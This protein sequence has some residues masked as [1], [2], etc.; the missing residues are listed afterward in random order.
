MLLDAL[1]GGLTQAQRLLRVHTPL[2]D[3]VLLAEDVEAWEGVGPADGPALGDARAFDGGSAMAVDI[4]AAWAFE[5]SLG[6]ARAGMRLVVHA[7]A[8]DAHIELKH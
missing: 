4:D 5:A 3:D 2:G 7:L 6:P 8:S 1:L